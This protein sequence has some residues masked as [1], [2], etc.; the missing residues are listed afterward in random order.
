MHMQH[1]LLSSND[2]KKAD[3]ERCLYST[4]NIH[5]KDNFL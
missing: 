3:D 4:A 5:F 2:S 1:N